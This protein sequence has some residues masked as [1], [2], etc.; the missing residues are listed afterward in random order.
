MDSS[1]TV[2]SSVTSEVAQKVEK[3]TNFLL[4]YWDNI[5]W[6]DIIAIFITKGIQLLI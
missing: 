2:D 5:K 6:G 4:N 1:S 3:S